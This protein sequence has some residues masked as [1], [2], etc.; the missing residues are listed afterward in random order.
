MKPIE[1][2]YILSVAITK[3]DDNNSV[4]TVISSSEEHKSEENLKKREKK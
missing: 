2:G 1:D 3:I 4:H